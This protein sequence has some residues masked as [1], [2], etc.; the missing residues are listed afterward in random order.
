MNAS[1]APA[2]YSEMTA[3][4]QEGLQGS[5]LAE[6]LHDSALTGVHAPMEPLP[7]TTTDNPV[8]TVEMMTIPPQPAG[9][10][11]TEEAHF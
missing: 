11:R 10:G 1:E 4:L 8:I 3:S 2:G 9:S 5:G 7:R 6:V